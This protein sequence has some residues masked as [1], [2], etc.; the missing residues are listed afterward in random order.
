MGVWVGCYAVPGA[1]W[2]WACVWVAGGARVRL[3]SLV[4]T[5]DLLLPLTALILSLAPATGFP[6]EASVS[7]MYCLLTPHAVPA[8]VGVASHQVP[9]SPLLPVMSQHRPAVLSAPAVCPGH[10]GRTKGTHPAIVELVTQVGG[11]SMGDPAR[12]PH[13]SGWPDGKGVGGASGWVAAAGEGLEVRG[14]R[15][16]VVEGTR[17]PGQESGSSQYAQ[18]SHGV[19]GV[20]LLT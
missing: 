20:R 6:A 18:W 13:S 4:L 17:R 12:E 1:A 9:K 5:L 19:L 3:W 16:P 2:H 8:L 15:R 10:T 11:S 14:W 7:R